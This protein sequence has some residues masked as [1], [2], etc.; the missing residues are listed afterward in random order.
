MKKVFF[1]DFDGTI[2]QRD[3][4]DAMVSAFAR[5]GWQ[6]IN[7]LWER[8][9][10]STEECANRTFRLFN[11]SP[12]DLYRLLDT[13]EIDQSFPAFIDYCQKADHPVYVVSDGYD[14]CIKYIFKKHNINLPYYANK[15]IYD[16]RFRISCTYHNAECGLCGTCKQALIQRLAE[17]GSKRIYIGDGLSDTCPAGH[18]DIVFAKGRLLEYCRL[19]GIA[20]VPINGFEDVLRN[21][22]D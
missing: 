13:I 18:S 3:T 17:P 4:C 6:Q 19:N 7:H 16:G 2:T 22:A 14:F 15:L 10:I 12:D 8:K 21:L 20:A 5:D 11:A 9:E 1:V